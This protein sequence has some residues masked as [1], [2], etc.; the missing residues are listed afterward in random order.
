MANITVKVT[1]TY[2]PDPENPGDELP[3]AVTI[4]VVGAEIITI[5]PYGPFTTDANGEVAITVP[6]GW[7]PY[8]MAFDVT[9]STPGGGEVVYGIDHQRV[10]AGDVIEVEV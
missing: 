8:L 10:Q 9:G 7:G 6:A 3:D 2:R 1:H 5:A 4:P